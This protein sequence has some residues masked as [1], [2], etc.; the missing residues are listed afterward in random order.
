MDMPEPFGHLLFGN[1][2]VVV[3]C[4]QCRATTDPAADQCPVCGATGVC[5]Y[6]I[7]G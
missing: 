5:R 6:E 4:Q 1:G 7:E 3:E 2:T